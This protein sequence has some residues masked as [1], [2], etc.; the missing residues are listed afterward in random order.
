MQTA[1]PGLKHLK[2]QAMKKDAENQFAPN[3]QTP[4]ISHAK[5]DFSTVPT[6][7]P[8]RQARLPEGGGSAREDD[9]DPLSSLGAVAPATG[10]GPSRPVDLEDVCTL[11]L[12]ERPSKGI[13]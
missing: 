7:H 2:T 1:Q 9:P 5:N 11:E 10:T 12:G 13:T 4:H 3:T 8:F 6:P